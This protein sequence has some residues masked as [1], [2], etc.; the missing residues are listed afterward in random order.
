MLVVSEQAVVAGIGD[1]GWERSLQ[2]QGFDLAV[3]RPIIRF[4]HQSTT[5]WILSNVFPFL[6]VAF[7]QAQN[8]IE[9]FLLLERSALF[10]A[11][12]TTPDFIDV[13]PNLFTGPLL[14]LLHE[15]SQWFSA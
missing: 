2:H 15:H 11:G 1:P 3:E 12:T 9:K 6:T 10:H 8:V 14:Q 13:A 5:D 7:A 4:F